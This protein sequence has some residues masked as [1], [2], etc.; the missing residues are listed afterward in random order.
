[1][2]EFEDGTELVELACDR[3]AAKWPHVPKA[4]PGRWYRGNLYGTGPPLESLLGFL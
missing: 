2:I 4:G 3:F 1:M